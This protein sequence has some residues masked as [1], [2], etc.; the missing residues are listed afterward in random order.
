VSKTLDT[1]RL[2]ERDLVPWGFTGTSYTQDVARY[3][4]ALY[5][6]LDNGSDERLMKLL[7]YL[8]TNYPLKGTEALTEEAFSALLQRFSEQ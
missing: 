8:R 4:N 3:V 1:F 2:S 5:Q 7:H 6:V